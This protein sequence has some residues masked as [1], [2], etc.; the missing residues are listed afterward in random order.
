MPTRSSLSWF[1]GLATSLVRWLDSWAVDTRDETEDPR[2]IDWIRVIPFLGIHLCCLF[3]FVVGWSPAAVTVAVGYYFVRMFAITAF[4]HRYFS[5]R[6]FETSRVTQF[7]FALL[8]SA[9]VQRGPIW[10]A[11]HHRA[12]HRHADRDGDVHSPN[13]DGFWWSHVGWLLARK[14]FKPR[15]DLVRDLTAFPELRWIDRFDVLVPALSIP[16]FWCLGE[17]LGNLG[18]A[19]TGGQML[20]WGFCISTV[21]TYHVTFSIN[22]VAHRMG[23]RRFDT[24]D[25]SRNNTL[26]ALLTLGEGWHNNHHRYQASARQGF[27]WWELDLSYCMLRVLAVFGVVRGLRPVPRRVLREGKRQ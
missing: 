22:S 8:G 26:L 14:N 1:R 3:V 20:V 23:S 18:M 16:A 2:Q 7:L 4:Y 25:D 15:L 21:V 10:W 19:T 27:F 17:L 24:P 12:H 9:A 13:R 5:H 11:S 6:S